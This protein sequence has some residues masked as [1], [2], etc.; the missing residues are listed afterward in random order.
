M[1]HSYDKELM[2]ESGLAFCVNCKLAEG[3]LTTDCCGESVANDVGEEIYNG[4]KDFRN[5]MG[6]CNFPNPTN[7][8]L[9]K[10]NIFKAVRENNFDKDTKNKIKLKFGLPKEEYTNIE[11]ECLAYLY[12]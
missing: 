4:R 12:K 6:W 3:S 2:A 7:Q 5:G 8:S 9:V 10:Q 1:E 11:K